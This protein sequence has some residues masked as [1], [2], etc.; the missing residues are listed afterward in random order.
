MTPLDT[1][2]NVCRKPKSWQCWRATEEPITGACCRIFPPDKAIACRSEKVW[3]HAL[4]MRRTEDEETCEQWLSGFISC[5]SCIDNMFRLHLQPCCFPV[6]PTLMQIL[7]NYS[8]LKCCVKL[9]LLSKIADSALSR[10]SWNDDNYV[11]DSPLTV[12]LK[13]MVEAQKPP[14]Y[15]IK[16]WGLGGKI[17]I[18]MWFFMAVTLQGRIEQKSILQLTSLYFSHLPK[19]SINLL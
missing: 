11:L 12:R 15:L 2:L 9:K 5:H 6:P 7:S 3:H 16:F 18:L 8:A 4:E 17:L 14:K 10:R 1:V 13:L 19:G